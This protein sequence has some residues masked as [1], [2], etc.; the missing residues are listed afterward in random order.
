M[1]ERDAYSASH[2]HRKSVHFRTIPS[3]TRL[4]RQV[5]LMQLR[6]LHLLEQA[7]LISPQVTIT[8]L[9]CKIL[10]GWYDWLHVVG[11]VRL[12]RPRKKRP[13]A[14]LIQARSLTRPPQKG[15]SL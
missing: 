2:A 15:S 8:S 11:T 5:D 4:K 6:S 1:V 7:P 12:T 9:A 14:R 3:C 13:I 10:M